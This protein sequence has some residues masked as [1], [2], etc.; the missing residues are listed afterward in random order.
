MLWYMLWYKVWLESRTRFLISLLGITALCVLRVYYGM[1][2][3]PAWSLSGVAYYYFVLRSGQQLLQ[4]AWVVAVTLL[5]MGGLLQEKT[6]G[7]APFTLAL[8]VSRAR[9]MSV[10][11][12]A[13]LIEAALLIAVPWAAMYAT[14]YF[15]APAL[16]V[17]QV[18]FYAVLL[19]G[20]GAVYAGMSL[21]ISSLVEGTYTAPMISAGFVL[22]CGTAPR[23]LAFMN[24]M[25]FMN[26]HDYMGSGNMLAG[27]IPWAHAAA[28]MTV[29]ALLIVASVKV[30]ERRDF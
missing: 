28:Y 10:R 8:P 24:P 11:I 19:A 30:I 15:S 3:A 25:D 29:A 7:S 5:M 13:G 2:G 4:L 23:E 22:V 27:P 18:L 16:S 26:G 20:G 1:R 17:S 21:L 14:A 9:L 12:S 6:N